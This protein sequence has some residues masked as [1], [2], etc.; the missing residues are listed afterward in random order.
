MSAPDHA[1]CSSKKFFLH[2]RGRPHMSMTTMSPLRNS[3]TRTRS[4]W[5]SKALRLI[6]PSST[7]GAIL[8]RVVRLATKVV[9]FQWPCGTPTRRRSPRRQRPWVRAML[10]EAQVSS[11]RTK[12]SGSRSS[13]PLNQASRR[14]KMSGRSCSE[15]CAVFF[16]RDGVAGEEAADRPV[17]NPHAFVRERLAQLFD[18]DVG[19]RF[20]KGKALMVLSLRAKL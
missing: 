5:V 17:A 3:G 16:A 18:R 19:R 1:P 2:R 14:F 4:T 7:K 10:V 8:P 15:A 11:I 20:N 13:W 6:G 9:V 12:R